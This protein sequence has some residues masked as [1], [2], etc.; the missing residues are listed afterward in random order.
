MD[1]TDSDFTLK[2]EPGRWVWATVSES[3]ELTVSGQLLHTE[4]GLMQEWEWS[5]TVGAADVPRLWAALGEV[6]AAALT[7]Q[8]LSRH[9][10]RLADLATLAGEAGVELRSWSRFDAGHND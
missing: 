5:D 3:G 1:E 4:D 8:V 2:S 9:R 10:D 6:G 7:P